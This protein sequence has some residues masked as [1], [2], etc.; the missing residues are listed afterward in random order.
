MKKFHYMG[1]KNRDFLAVFIKNLIFGP[2]NMQFII[3][4]YLCGLN[5]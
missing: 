3:L 2:D 5:F 4:F 1:K